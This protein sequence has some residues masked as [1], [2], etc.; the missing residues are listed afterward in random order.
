M[1]GQVCPSNNIIIHKSI[2]EVLKNYKRIPN[3]V[4]ESI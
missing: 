4:K 1:R 2:K 3:R